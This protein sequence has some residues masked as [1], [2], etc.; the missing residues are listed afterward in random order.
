MPMDQ[1]IAEGDYLLAKKALL[2][3]KVKKIIEFHPNLFHHSI[4]L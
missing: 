2:I 3:V 4:F 1:I